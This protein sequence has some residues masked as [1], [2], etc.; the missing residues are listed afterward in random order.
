MSSNMK[1]KLNELNHMAC[2][3]CGGVKLRPVVMGMVEWIRK[4]IN[5]LL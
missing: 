3:K 1:D 2:P 5:Q 4:E